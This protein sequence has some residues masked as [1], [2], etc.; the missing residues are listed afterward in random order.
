MRKIIV[1]FFLFLLLSCN[2]KESNEKSSYKSKYDIVDTSKFENQN[3]K[4]DPYGVLDITYAVIVS[5]Q[6]ICDIYNNSFKE[7]KN[8]GLLQEYMMPQLEKCKFYREVYKKVI[9]N[10]E[11]VNLDNVNKYY[12]FNYSNENSETSFSNVIGIFSNIDSCNKAKEEF[13][14][15]E[16]G[17]TSK[18]KN[19]TKLMN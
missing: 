17:L 8:K 3:S 1:I 5:Q 12:Y 13:L 15:K 9:P 4:T 18:C 11:S 6:D 14:D 16:M 19:I 7:S 2:E 10:F